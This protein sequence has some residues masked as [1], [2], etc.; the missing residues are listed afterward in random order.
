MTPA[1]QPHSIWYERRLSTPELVGCA[2]PTGRRLTVKISENITQILIEEN[3][4]IKCCGCQPK[5]CLDSLYCRP[6]Y[7]PQPN[8][9][10][11]GVKLRNS[12]KGNPVVQSSGLHCTINS[13]SYLPTQ[14]LTQLHECLYHWTTS[15]TS[16]LA[17]SNLLLYTETPPAL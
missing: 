13:P 2:W 11:A 1:L 17:D 12:I 7:H 16:K 4:G 3:K 15:N 14:L 8:S 6:I 9:S 10:F 5:V